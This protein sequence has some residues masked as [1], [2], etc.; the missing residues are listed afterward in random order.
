MCP[1]GVG[2]SLPDTGWSL[3]SS[4]FAADLSCMRLHSHGALE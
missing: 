3:T 4:A 1:G 2:L